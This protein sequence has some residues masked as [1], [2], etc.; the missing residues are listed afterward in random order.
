PRSRRAADGAGSVND[1]LVVLTGRIVPQRPPGTGAC[2]VRG[3]ARRPVPRH[4]VA[5]DGRASPPTSRGVGHHEPVRILVAPDCFTGTLTAAQAAEAM[6][7][8]WRRGAPSDS[9]TLL[10]LADGGPGF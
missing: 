6:A 10:P 2:P 4:A 9:T 3:T 5:G 1:G 7:D 8:G